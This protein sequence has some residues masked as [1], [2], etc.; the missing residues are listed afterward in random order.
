[1]TRL[2]L[3]GNSLAQPD[4][5]AIDDEPKK[6]RPVPSPRRPA[7]GP[8][9]RT[10]ACTSQKRYGY[11]STLYTAKPTDTLDAFLAQL[12]PSLAVDLMSGET[13]PAE[14]TMPQQPLH[15]AMLPQAA[16]FEG[17]AGRTNPFWCDVGGARCVVSLSRSLAEASP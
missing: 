9:T 1:M 8:L 17:F 12:A 15:P 10:R 13:D 3:A 4:L 6:V 5:S 16:A 7:P 14:P 2:I 11:D